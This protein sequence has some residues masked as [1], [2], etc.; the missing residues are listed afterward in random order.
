MCRGIA[1]GGD[2]A[3]MIVDFRDR[4]LESFFFDDKGSRH[5]PADLVDR[6]FRRLQMLD[7][8]TSTLDLLVPPSNNFEQLRG[9]L[10]DL[11]SIRV[12]KQWRLIFRWNGARGEA[13]GVYLDDHSYR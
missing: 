12:N 5:F 6:L 13:S 3:L 1:G 9:K 11:S 7:D 10:D 4:W 2:F 8:A